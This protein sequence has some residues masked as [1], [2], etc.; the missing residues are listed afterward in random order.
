MKT[1]LLVFLSGFILIGTA[2]AEAPLWPHSPALKHIGR[3]KV[4]ALG[5]RNTL[6]LDRRVAGSTIV[7]IGT[8]RL[9][10]AKAVH[11]LL[12]TTVVGKTVDLFANVISLD[13]HGR[14]RAQIVTTDKVWLQARLLQSGVAVV[15]PYPGDETVALSLYPYETE[16]RA[17]KTGIWAI[18]SYQIIDNREAQKFTGQFKLVTAKIV[19]AARIKGTVYLNFGDNW[20]DDFTVEIPRTAYQL[21]KQRG[22]DPLTF[23]GRRIRVRGWIEEKNGPMI[24]IT[25]PVQ[26]EFVDPPGYSP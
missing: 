26:I 5:K 23:T 18:S 12:E 2:P 17:N 3:A 19:A 7:Y 4:I 1:V 24:R 10:N 20:R 13:R 16:A 25:N 14:L 6:V 21:L 11:R 15:D 8:L 9:F 22:I